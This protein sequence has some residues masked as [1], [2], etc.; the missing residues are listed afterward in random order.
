[1]HAATP[2]V[3]HPASRYALAL[4]PL[5]TACA[6]E[7][8]PNTP[9]ASA[10]DGSVVD[11]ST[12][13]A[14]SGDASANDGST[15]DALTVDAST[16]DVS[17]VDA[18]S[19]E[20]PCE[21]RMV[22]RLAAGDGDAPGPALT[23]VAGGDTVRDGCAAWF[24]GR[25]ATARFVAPRAGR[26]TFTAR[27]D[28]LW[29]FSTRVP[30]GDSDTAC[31][32]NLDGPGPAPF[33]HPLTITR[34]LREGESLDLVADGCPSNTRAACRWTLQARHEPARPD[35]ASLERPCFAGQRCVAWRA[36]CE[37]AVSDTPV[38]VPAIVTAVAVR[39]GGTLR[40]LTTFRDP[41]VNGGAGDV[42]VRLLDAGGVALAPVGGFVDN[43]GRAAFLRDG[44]LVLGGAYRR[45]TPG[46]YSA[47]AIVREPTGPTARTAEF[48][49]GETMLRVVIEDVA[50]LPDGARCT[51][52]GLFDVC[53]E[54]SA[55]DPTE[56]CRPLVAPVIRA[57]SAW[58]T[59]SNGLSALVV[60]WDD[61]NGDVD[62][63]EHL[64]V[65]RS[66]M[67]V[68][69]TPT[70]DGDVNLRAATDLFDGATEVTVRVHDRSGR[71][72]EPVTVP[73]RGPVALDVGQVCDNAGLFSRCGEDAIC[74]RYGDPSRCVLRCD[75]NP[76]VSGRCDEF[77]CVAP[78]HACPAGVSVENLT[79]D[80]SGAVTV[81]GTGQGAAPVRGL[82]LIH[83]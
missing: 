33:A 41:G 19:T 21:A 44:A 74:T 52:R 9:D 38:D 71:W 82:S 50:T 14:S 58:R 26:W 78:V 36:V 51:V 69:T 46:V 49:F 15:V 62:L 31:A 77:R 7:P 39:V 66:A 55:C 29:S 25:D 53:G 35:C 63:V 40:F 79:P 17:S 64:A 20:V 76:Y 13:D 70:G 67:P 18:G 80:A 23:L 12:V 28:S 24:N 1:M 22:P 61:P 47:E 73:V 2:A 37:P 75:A 59:A 72:S 60:R 4:L 81:E 11:G 83:I 42:R 68:R 65:G 5:L 57:A 8:T 30:C 32:R 43:D 10:A 3:M 48:L 54:G 45:H 56:V 34:E 27:G 6:T 16:T